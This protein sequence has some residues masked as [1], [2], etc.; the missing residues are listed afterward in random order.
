[1]DRSSRQNIKKNTVELNNTINQITDIYKL[2]HT[3]IVEYTFFSF[4]HG[5]FTKTDHTIDHKTQVIIF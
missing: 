2:F 5:R 4:S 3:R 1:M